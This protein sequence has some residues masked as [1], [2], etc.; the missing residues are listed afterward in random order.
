MTAGTVRAHSELQ[1]RLRIRT[2]AAVGVAWDTLGSYNDSDLDRWFATVVPLVG[3]AQV[4]Q[5]TLTA[6]Y[7][8][9]AVVEAGAAPTDRSID[10][11]RAV[12]AAV[13]NGIPPEEVYR[14]PF[15]TVWAALK[16]GVPWISAV[17]AGRR[18]AVTAADLDL[19]L[20]DRQAAHDA[21]ATQPS[22]V[23]WRR[24]L[25]AGH[26]CGLCIAASTQRYHVGD[27]RPIH[28]RCRCHTEPIVGEADPGRIINRERLAA[29]KTRMA[30]RNITFGGADRGRLSHIR[31]DVVEHGEL[32]PKLVNADHHFT[33]PEAIPA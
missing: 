10:P 2:I 20:A 17:A 31:Y 32:G 16:D 22:V 5:A 18:R 21:M 8:R 4:Q 1:W 7:I 33:G 29:L 30:E 28:E 25:G 27:L 26:N 13:R 12:G 11:E 6:G 3:A 9:R 15:V 24:V 14:R 23:G 19:Q